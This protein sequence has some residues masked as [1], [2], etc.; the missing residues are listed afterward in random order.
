MSP[1]GTSPKF[2]WYVCFEYL[3]HSLV[4]THFP[5]KFWKA[6]LNPPIPAN[7]SI[8]LNS[9]FFGA[10]KGMFPCWNIKY[11]NAYSAVIFD[12]FSSGNLYLNKFITCSIASG[13]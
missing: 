8:N 1:K 7:K 11:C 6:S 4:K 10:G 3:S 13:L 5:F 12:I 2:A 9:G